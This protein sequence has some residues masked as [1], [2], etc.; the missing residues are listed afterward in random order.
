[1][2]FFRQ[3]GG[4]CFSPFLAL[5]TSHQPDG[6]CLRSQLGQARKDTRVRSLRTHLGFCFLLLLFPICLRPR[7]VSWCRH[8][9]LLSW[10][11]RGWEAALEFSE[12][13]LGT[14]AVLETR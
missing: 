1:M 3:V 13:E 5:K 14:D 2:A 10:N 4:G 11:W 9:C 6:R 12:L 8:S 7:R